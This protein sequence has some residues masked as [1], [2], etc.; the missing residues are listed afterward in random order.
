MG[1]FSRKKKSQGKIHMRGFPGHVDTCKCLY[2]AAEKGLHIDTD[3]LDLTGHE[4]EQ[5]AYLSLS[6]FGKIPCLGDGDI[7]ISGAA[8]ILPYI[9]IKG[10]G[11]SL[12]PRKAVRLGEQNYWI[13]VGEYRVLPHITTLLEEEVLR[14]M[15]DP[16][17]APDQ[18]KIAAALS[19]IDRVFGYA[20]KHLE[21]KD[22]FTSDYSFAEVHWAPYLHFCDITGHGDLLGKRPELKLWFDRIKARKNG[23]RLTYDVFPTLEQVKG[24]ELKC[25]A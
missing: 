21:D 12:A 18:E 1:L 9:D 22:Y 20:D 23:T 14:P 8:A 16:G 5:G 4:H 11:Q 15:S 13:E 7:V 3:L 19:E 6:P 2:L 25:A 24:K 10:G 17:Y